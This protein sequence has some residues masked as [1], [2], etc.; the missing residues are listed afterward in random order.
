MFSVEKEVKI[1]DNLTNEEFE[2]W[3][4]ENIDPDSMGFNGVEG[5]NEDGNIQ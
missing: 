5:G 1:P 2:R 3:I 4:N